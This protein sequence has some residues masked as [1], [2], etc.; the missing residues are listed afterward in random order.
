ME[1][2]ERQNC[3]DDDDKP[4]QIN[5]VVHVSI[6]CGWFQTEL[7]HSV[8][9]SDPFCKNCQD[10]HDPNRNADKPKTKCAHDEALSLFQFKSMHS[11]AIR[12]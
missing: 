5:D 4:Y 2:E 8:G 9:K 7:R 1:A 3:H 12:R 6:L 11:N 10:D